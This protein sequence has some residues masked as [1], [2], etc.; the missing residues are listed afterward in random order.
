VE[1]EAFTLIQNLLS[2]VEADV[3]WVDCL[4]LLPVS[5]RQTI[6]G[7]NVAPQVTGPNGKANHTL[8]NVILCVQWVRHFF[9]HF[10]DNATLATIYEDLQRYAQGDKAVG[11]F[12]YNHPAVAWIFTRLW[13][14]RITYQQALKAEKEQLDRDWE[15]LRRENETKNDEIKSRDRRIRALFGCT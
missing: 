14:A 10:R 7:S 9:V 6:R 8:P 4:N 3:N 13:Q 1:N 11:V 2:K 12:I 5:V 15:R